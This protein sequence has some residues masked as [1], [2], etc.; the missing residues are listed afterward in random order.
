M[1]RHG[2]CAIG[3]ERPTRQP[4]AG[5]TSRRDHPRHSDISRSSSTALHT[6]PLTLVT[7]LRKGRATVSYDDPATD[8]NAVTERVGAGITR[9]MPARQ[10]P[11]PGHVARWLVTE[12]ITPVGTAARW[13]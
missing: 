5:H 8:R 3:C 2:S 9:I 4:A 13:S 6:R 10:S 11:C 12:I 1:P 7:S